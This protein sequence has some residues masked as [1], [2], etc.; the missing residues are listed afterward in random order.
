MTDLPAETIPSFSGPEP[1]EWVAIKQEV[2]ADHIE[3]L[4]EL[5]EEDGYQEFEDDDLDIGLVEHMDV[6][7]LMDGQN[8]D[9]L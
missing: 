9:D 1:V 5:E 4:Q 2:D 3:L 7:A 8:Y 6:L